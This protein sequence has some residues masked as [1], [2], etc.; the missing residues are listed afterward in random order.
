ML[1]TVNG[2]AVDVPEGMTLKEYLLSRALNPETVVVELNRSIVPNSGWEAVV[3]RE[4]DTMEIL[5][6]VGGG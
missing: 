5:S 3:L 4:N 1:L 2:G 6:F